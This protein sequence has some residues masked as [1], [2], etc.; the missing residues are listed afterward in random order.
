MDCGR[1]GFLFSLN[2]SI[3]PMHARSKTT[4]MVDIIIL[5]GCVDTA[6]L[7]FSIVHG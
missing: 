7:I 6:W 2:H 4:V 5:P 3:V 1:S